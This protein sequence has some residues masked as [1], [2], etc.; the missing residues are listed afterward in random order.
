M[1]RRYP[2]SNGTEGYWRIG[3]VN[4]TGLMTS[5]HVMNL[6]VDVDNIGGRGDFDIA[7]LRLTV[8]YQVLQ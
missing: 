2:I 6:G 1:G 8:S 5:K 4:P 3:T 7:V